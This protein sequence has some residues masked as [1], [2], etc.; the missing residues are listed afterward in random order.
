MLKE[1]ARITATPLWTQSPW[2][3]KKVAEDWKKENVTYITQ[4]SQ[5]E[6]WGDL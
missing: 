1:L 5:E 2:S 3:L 6:L 4:E